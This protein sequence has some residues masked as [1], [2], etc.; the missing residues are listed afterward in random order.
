MTV[1]GTLDQQELADINKLLDAIASSSKKFLAGKIE[2]GLHQLAKIDNLGSIASFEASF[3][4][5]RQASATS[6]TQVSRTDPAQSSGE[7]D[8]APST[9][10]SS[11][12]GTDSFIDQLARVVQKLHSENGDE[13]IPKR[14]AQL[15]RKL[16]DHQPLNTR[17]QTLIDRLQ[18]EHSKRGHGH[19]NNTLASEVS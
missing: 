7:T 15:F 19:H 14:F 4:Y 18:S 6:T 9:A 12:Q 8:T 16:A 10:A 11:P 5:S 3:S 13:Q 2:N 1:D 17:E